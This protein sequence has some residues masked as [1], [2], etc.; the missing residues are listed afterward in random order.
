VTPPIELVRELPSRALPTYD[1]ALATVAAELAS[2][3]RCR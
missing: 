2:D 1:V 3:C